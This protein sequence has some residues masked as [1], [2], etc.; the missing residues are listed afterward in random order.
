[1][2]N[3]C[4]DL[5]RYCAQRHVVEENPGCVIHQLNYIVRSLVIIDGFRFGCLR[6]FVKYI[7]NMELVI[8]REVERIMK[9]N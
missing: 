3:I 4:I 2:H 8:K 7:I 1:M 6:L 9:F 5:N